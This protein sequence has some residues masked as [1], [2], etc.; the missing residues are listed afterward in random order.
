VKPDEPVRGQG[1]RDA[2][3]RRLDPLTISVI[4]VCTVVELT[5]QLADLGLLDAPRLR[6][7]AYTYGGFWPGLLGDWRPNFAGQPAVMFL[8]YSFL[9]AGFV[10]LLV[11][12]LTLA[13]LGPAV[14]DRG[15]PA[16]YTGIY[17]VS[18]LG[19]ALAYGL[20]APGVA[21]MVGASGGLFGLAGAVLAWDTAERRA[22]RLGLRPV[23]RVVVFLVVMNLVLWWAM[24]GQ[25]AW[26]AHLGGFLAG[27]A[28]ATLLGERRGPRSPGPSSLS[29]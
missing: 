8:S 2:L 13:S 11:N 4:G 28:L 26:E 24:S 19:G 17:V 6:F 3:V 9:H 7:V 29:D 12:M 27:A 15:G 23:L 10:H 21:P 25:L 1:V 5:L 14:H 16:R 22:L 18:V 20:L